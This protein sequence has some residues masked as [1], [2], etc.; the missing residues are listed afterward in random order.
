MKKKNTFFEDELSEEEIDLCESIVNKGYFQLNKK[1]KE[2]LNFGLKNI[3]QFQ[4]Y[5]TIF[6]ANSLGCLTGFQ[7]TILLYDASC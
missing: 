5:K 7:K 2:S 1:L 4:L 6:N 3:S